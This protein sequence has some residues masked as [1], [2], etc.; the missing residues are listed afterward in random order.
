MMNTTTVLAAAALTGALLASAAPA[1][2]ETYAQL[3]DR[4]AA[5]IV[6]EDF[7]TGLVHSRDLVALP[8]LTRTQQA[9]AY[10][11]LC[12]NL[13]QIGRSTEALRAC[14]EAVAR[15]AGAWGAYVNRGN[16]RSAVGDRLA[17]RADYRKAKSL[18]PSQPAVD[19]AAT[20]QARTP[21]VFFRP[22]AGI[23]TQQ[24]QGEQVLAE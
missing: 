10:T 23:A 12:I 19:V 1:R 22:A 5:A 4:S 18:S 9:V 2:A 16:V 13:S 8:H 15:D 20:L 21:Y 14:D 11:H 3:L 6:A 24:A 17:A 7:R